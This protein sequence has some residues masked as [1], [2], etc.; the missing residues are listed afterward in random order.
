MTDNIYFKFPLQIEQLFSEKS[1][2]MFAV[3]F[4]QKID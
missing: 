4:Q 2:R 1:Y 3:I